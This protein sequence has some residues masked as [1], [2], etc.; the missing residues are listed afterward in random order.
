[1]KVGNNFPAVPQSGASART[2]NTLPAPINSASAQASRAP[3]SIEAFA[4]TASSESSRFF[5]TEGLSM[6]AQQALSAYLHT[7]S[8]SASNP[9]NQL[10]GI[11][12][13]A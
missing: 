2:P 11:D 8:L 9:R 1:M 13:Y 6:Q 3:S 12:V 4:Q 5:K 10:V 7:E